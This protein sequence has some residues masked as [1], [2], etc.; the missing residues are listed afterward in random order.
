[1]YTS[2]CELVGESAGA[3]GIAC[4]PSPSGSAG[5][6][7]VTVTPGEEGSHR[8]TPLIGSGPGGPCWGAHPI[9]S[10]RVAGRSPAGRRAA[11]G[12]SDTPSSR[13]SRARVRGTAAR[14]G[15]APGELAH[16]LGERAGPAGDE[17]QLV[18]G[19]PARLGRAQVAHEVDDRRQVVGLEGQQPLVVPERE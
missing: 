3:G 10:A 17:R 19:V 13:A 7:Q 11:A 15:S 8:R 4:R 5:R 12:T 9:P 14:A 18:A 6:T 16:R 2:A 1:M